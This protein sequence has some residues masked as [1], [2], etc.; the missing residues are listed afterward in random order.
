M[1][2]SGTR[3]MPVN[4]GP[5]NFGASATELR[6]CAGVKRGREFKMVAVAAMVAVSAGSCGCAPAP[7]PPTPKYGTAKVCFQAVTDI[8]YGPFVGIYTGP[9][10][11]DALIE[12]SGQQISTVETSTRGCIT[13]KLVAGYSWRFRVYSFQA[14]YYWVGRST[15]KKVR[16]GGTYDYGTVTLDSIYGG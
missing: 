7:P 8:G 5:R 13:M 4:G 15:W 3:G 16:S 12:G 11:V 10:N 6:S 14:N 2:F 1:M 9:V